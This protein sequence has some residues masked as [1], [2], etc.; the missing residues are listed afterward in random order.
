MAFHLHL[1]DELWDVIPAASPR[2]QHVER[3]NSAGSL[4][5]RWGL[6]ADGCLQARWTHARD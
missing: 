3:V 1:I 2:R 6:G 5:S 4:I